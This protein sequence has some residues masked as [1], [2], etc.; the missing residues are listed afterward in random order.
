MIISSST[1]VESTSGFGNDKCDDR[2]TT[3][4]QGKA[5]Q[6]AYVSACQR[7]CRG[8]N[9]DNWPKDERRNLDKYK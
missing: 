6:I 7:V 1:T 2:T 4:E 9:A 8:Q 3:A 5:K